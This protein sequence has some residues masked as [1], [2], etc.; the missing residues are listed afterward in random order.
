[1]SGLLPFFVAGLGFLFI[2][3]VESIPFSSAPSRSRYLPL[4]LRYTSSLTLSSL[5]LLSSLLSLSLSLSTHSHDP[6]GASLPL[7]SLAAS[8]FFLLYSLS[9][10]LSLPPLSLLPLPSS[11]LDL[12]AFFSF[13]LQFIF[14]YLR[15]KDLDG[16]E[17]RYFDLLLV[18][19]LLCILSTLLIIS[20]PTS[21]VPRLARAAGLALQGTWFLQMAFSFFTSAISHGCDIHHKSRANYTI[22]CKTH[23]D[24]HRARAIATLQFNCHLALLI[25]TATVIYGLLARNK[26]SNH[27]GYR[28]LNKELQMG[29]G[30]STFTLDSDEE[31]TEIVVESNGHESGHVALHAPDQNGTVEKIS[32][33]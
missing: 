21:L 7:S 11:F 27:N 30:I 9:G 32:R 1:M 23:E 6:L 28:P 29:T 31:D 20:F 14:F 2:S 18:P 17:N 13:S 15:R 24:Y 4:R 19:I 5:F 26:P 25:V 33:D 3:A 10:L 22:K 8:S 12:L 16:I